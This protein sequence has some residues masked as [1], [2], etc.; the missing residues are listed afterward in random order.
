[1]IR[2]PHGYRPCL[3]LR[4]A[5]RADLSALLKLEAVCFDT[6]RLSRRSLLWFTRP[7]HDV[8]HPHL[9]IVAEDVSVVG[10]ALLLWRRRA[11]EKT[12]NTAR[13]YSLAVSPAHTGQGIARALLRHLFT[14]AADRGISRIRLE[15]DPE[16]HP[17]MALYR[18]LGFAPVASL[19]NYYENGRPALRLQRTLV[20]P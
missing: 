15:V 14:M 2:A 20:T 16:N 7:T 4:P 1:M 5:Q 19:P 10:Y 3:N 13:L 17:A 18:R 8:E 6:D 11:G 12:P 9:F